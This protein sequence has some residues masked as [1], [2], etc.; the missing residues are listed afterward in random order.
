M[1]SLYWEKSIF[2]MD[3]FKLQDILTEVYENKG[4][5]VKNMHKVDPRSENGADLEV[6]E[7]KELI[8]VAVKDKPA[9]KDIGQ[10]RRLWNRK[11]EAT[12]VYAYSKPSTGAFSAEEKKLSKDILFLH[13]EKLH[14]FLLEGESISYLQSI[15]ELHPLVQEYSRALS[16]VWNNRN[17]RIPQ[18]FVKEDIQ[19]L[20]SLKAA[21]LKKRTGVGLFSLKYDN[22]VNSLISKNSDEFN[23]IL[24]DVISNLDL[25]QQFAGVSLYES[26]EEV[27][28][29]APYLF[30]MLWDN[31]SQRTY[32]KEY[33]HYTK[34]LS[35]IN[36]VSEFTAKYWVLPSKHAIGEAGILSRNAIGFLSAIDDILT[37]ITYA[38]RQLDVAID[39]LF[40]QINGK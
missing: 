9:K 8:L 10:L 33:T 29:N 1:C 14:Y 3:E 2:R 7:G 5:Q 22:Y 23:K 17:V 30:S 12:L 13:D 20:Y 18:K 11:K 4:W 31:V 26:F 32:W 6:S 19:N 34:N 40:S 35:D 36:K 25:V 16:M 38:F 39:N 37:S 28:Q 27:A 24:N 21:L 15:F